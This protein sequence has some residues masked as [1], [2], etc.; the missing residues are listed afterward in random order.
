MADILKH[1]NAI[2]LA[3]LASDPSGA[4]NGTI[5]YNTTDGVVKQY[6]AGGWQEVPDQALTLTGLSL[7][8]GF[9][10]VGNGS[11][12]SASF[13]SASVGDIDADATAGLTIK[14][15]V[16]VNADINASAAIALS[17]L[18][19]VTASRALQ[20]D[21]SGFVSA[22]SV[23]STEL[24]YVSGVTSAIQTQLTNNADA[25]SNHLSDTT[26]AHDASAISNVPSGNLAATDVQGALNE[27]QSDIDNR[28]LD[29]VVIKKDGSVAFTANQSMGSNKLTSVANGT[30][31][32]DAVNKSQLDGVS[33]GLVWLL[34]ILDPDLID[35]NRAAQPGS[36]VNGDVY[37]ASATAG[38]W[39]AG[40]AYFSTDSGATWVD[41]L[42]RAVAINDRF[43]VSMESATSAVGV[44][45]GKDNYIVTVTTA[46][47][48]SIAFATEHAP[49][50]MDAVFVNADLSTHFGH[51]YTYDSTLTQWIEFGGT[52]ALNAGAGLVLSGNVLSV[53]MGAGIIQ[54]PTDEVGVDVHTAGGIMTTVDN[55][56]PST[57]TGAQ[58][59]LKLDG[60]T[61]AKSSSG[62]K[63]ATGG[64]TN[65]EVN[66]SAAIAYSKLNLTNSIVNADVNSSAAI[67]Y[68][69]LALSS[70]LVNADINASA[71]IDAT[72]IANGT[73]SNTEFQYLDGVTSAIQTQLGG[74]ANTALDNLATVAINTS[75]LP[76]SDAGIDVGSTSFQIASAFVK[77]VVESNTAADVG[78]TTGFR[79]ST[80]N[81]ISGSTANVFIRSGNNNAGAGT[82][83]GSMTVRS[84]DAS[85]ADGSSGPINV[86]S[87]DVTAATGAGVSGSWNARSGNITG[88]SSTG[89]SGA[90]SLNSGNIT[91]AGNSGT[92]TLNTGTVNTGT[93]GAITSKSGNATGTTGSSGTAFYGSGT[94][95]NGN[96]GAVTFGSGT[97]SGTGTSGN[98]QLASGTA[99]G[100]TRGTASV[101]GNTVI[102]G[103]SG[104]IQ[105]QLSIIPSTNN[106]RDLGSSALKFKDAYL[107]NS[108]VIEDPGA[109]TNNVTLQAAAATA[110]FTLT[111]P[112]ALPGS[113]QAVTLSA[114][115]QLGTSAFATASAGDIAETSYAGLVDNTAD[116]T[117][118]GFAFNNATA[119]SFKALV[120]VLVDATSDSFAVY[121]L[122]GIQRGSDWQMSQSFT[123]DSITG[124]SFNITSAGQVR[125]TI[126]SIAGF[127]SATI[128]FRAQ[129]T[130]V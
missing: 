82:F 105:P 84:G 80:K 43:G 76:A 104:S 12:V 110:A 90:V 50:A 37:I 103:G 35:A 46:T 24:G 52:S 8:D 106:T 94:A 71:A 28:A 32:A 53:N 31:P 11:N 27:L 85:V 74:K 1:G 48:G 79:I 118:T 26:D 58:L 20:S 129:T 6:I 7:N 30:N 17:K 75:L 99:T 49:V 4:E 15:G 40:H 39:T 121:E 59:A 100:G 86:R 95:I 127:S 122:M 47:P 109:G 93:S 3:Q 78:G 72:K 33:A 130:T 64:I 116:Q 61:L 87:G 44:L 62:V 51:Q 23:T 29:S 96:S 88:A 126:G 83:S 54:L 25:I 56:T 115:G 66:A 38:D 22:S 91:G 16:I 68:S 108:L 128:K 41:L 120:S 45:S 9:L 119:R 42:N 97:I 14:A 73:V 34:P 18:A 92:A 60:S 124:F 5:Y 10:I 57:V 63:V 123:G 117:V 67:A 19:A 98:V 55:S 65:T 2:R 69:K 89:S 21:G 101:L 114:T 113:T 125:A 70:S 107:G 111:L 36:P 102:L 77:N 81:D 13:D 112:S